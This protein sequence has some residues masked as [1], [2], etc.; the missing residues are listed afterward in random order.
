MKI[1]GEEFLDSI[2]SMIIILIVIVI[3]SVLKSIMENLGNSSSVAVA[4]FVQYL[5][6]V[7]LIINIF[8]DNIEIVKNAIEGNKANCYGEKDEL[9][10]DAPRILGGYPFTAYLKIA[11]G[12]DNCCTYC[13]IPKIRGRLRS[14]TIEDCVKEAQ[15]LASMG[16]TELIVVA[17]DTT[18]YGIDIY[19]EPKLSEL[20][21]ELCKIEIK[22]TYSNM[23]DYLE[24]KMY[25]VDIAYNALKNKGLTVFKRTI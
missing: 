7:S 21:K 17:Q 11:E 19:G 24:G 18:A 22:D 20:L 16:V 4:Y 2:R 14:R 13:A 5:I 9:D 25:V 15:K 1:F 10:L 23:K 6:I 12:C 3:H 8:V